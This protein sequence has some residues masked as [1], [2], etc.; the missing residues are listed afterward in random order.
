MHSSFDELKLYIENLL[1]AAK[2]TAF[3]LSYAIHI[4][5]SSG[6][7]WIIIDANKIEDSIACISAIGETIE[8]KG[9]SQHLLSAVFE[10]GKD[11]SQHQP[12]YLVYNY[13]LD[14][15][16]PFVPI[17][18]KRKARNNQEEMNIMRAIA[19]DRLP[20]EEDMDRW[21]PIWTLPF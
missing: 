15:F 8:Q 16:Y 6:Y 1:D 7:L 18:S 20:F 14:K 9:F 19:D 11:G 10:F 3:D 12:Y 13:E 4:D 21:Y 17:M 5:Y 2:K